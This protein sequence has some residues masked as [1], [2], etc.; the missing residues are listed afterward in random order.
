M[1][2]MFDPYEQQKGYR[3][4]VGLCTLI[5]QCTPGAQPHLA[6]DTHQSDSGQ[7]RLLKPATLL[8]DMC[9]C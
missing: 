9:N 6:P 8:N 1:T 7:V 2:R 4:M 3:L 5:A